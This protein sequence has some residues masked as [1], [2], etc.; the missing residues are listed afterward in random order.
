MKLAQSESFKEHCMNCVNPYGN[1]R[2]TEEIVR[3]IDIL[4]SN[5]ID[6]RKKFY[7]IDYEIE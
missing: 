4:L 5:K 2:T 3:Y 6:L 1:G 7:D